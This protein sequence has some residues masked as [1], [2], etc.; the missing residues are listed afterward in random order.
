MNRRDLT[1][2]V[3]PSHIEEIDAWAFAYCDRLSKIYIPD[4]VH[5]LG[6]DIFQGCSALKD[7]VVYKGTSASASTMSALSL[8]SVAADSVLPETAMPSLPQNCHEK[9]SR[10]TAIAFTHFSQPAL[11]CLRDVGTTAWLSMWEHTLLGY[12]AQPDDE[13]FDPFLASGEE[14]YEDQNSNPD[15][16]RHIRRMQK[17]QCILERLLLR[18]D[19]PPA[20]GLLTRLSDYLLRYSFWSADN[21]TPAETIDVLLEETE[22]LPAVF[23]LYESLQLLEHVSIPD[24][25][26]AL[27][28]EQVELKALLLT[29]SRPFDLCL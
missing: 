25:I 18:Q 29:Q 27:S 16:F 4:S 14:D 15:Y 10:L 1:E 28:P 17:I 13:G 12:I 19:Y 7:V 11:R 5:T 3:L 21:S 8:P 2:I 24:L 6:Q 9:L 23:K 20:S 22:R 26:S